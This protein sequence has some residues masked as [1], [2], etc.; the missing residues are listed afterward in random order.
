GYEDLD[1][2]DGSPG[3]RASALE[4]ARRIFTN[5]TMWN[6]ALASMMI[7]FVR[8]S[9]VDAWW[10]VYFKDTL[11]LTADDTAY[12]VA[13]LGTMLAGILGGFT[14]GIASDRAFGGRRAPV[15]TLGFAG[16]AVALAAF[17]AGDRPGGC[18]AALIALSFFVH[19]AHGMIGGASSL[20]FR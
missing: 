5:P 7:G 2:G 14:L 11:K 8:R 3:A 9:I 19:G 12:Q 1:T 20:D 4:V 16:M 6:I 13:A 15:V 17:A 18:I 10:P